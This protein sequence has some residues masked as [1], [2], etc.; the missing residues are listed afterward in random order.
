[1]ARNELIETDKERKPLRLHNS[2]MPMVA[3]LS[4]ILAKCQWKT[5]ILLPR[6]LNMMVV[7]SEF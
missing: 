1:M 2:L 3:F 5:Y 7:F 4:L 6:N